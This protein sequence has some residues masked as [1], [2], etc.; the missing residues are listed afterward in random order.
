M[1]DTNVF[2]HVL[3]GEIR[4]DAIMEDWELAITH[5]QRDELDE[6]PNEARRNAL[7]RKVTEVAA[8]KIPTESAVWGASQWGQA[9]WTGPSSQYVEIR[10]ELD[11]IKNKPNNVQ[12]ALIADTCLQKDYLLITND[13]RSAERHGK[14]RRIRS[15]YPIQLDAPDC[16]IAITVLHHHLWSSRHRITRNVPSDS[17]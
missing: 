5:I 9:K 17:W 4:P 16:L 7:K 11:T 6:T 10:A 2:N 14:A 12:D 1:F 13:G 15:G 8:T 3:D